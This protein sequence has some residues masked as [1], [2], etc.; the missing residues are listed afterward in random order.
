MEILLVILYVTTVACVTAW[1]IANL[2]YR[3]PRQRSL[4]SRIEALE[5]MS[6]AVSA[7]DWQE[8]KKEIAS[9]RLANGLRT[10]K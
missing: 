10:R 3:E 2:K 6:V 9:L 5:G 7:E 8:V 1:F 4:E